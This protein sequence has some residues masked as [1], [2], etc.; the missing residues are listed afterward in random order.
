[1]IS[2]LLFAS[3]YM[4]RS[5]SHKNS[6]CKQQLSDAL[7][8]IAMLDQTVMSLQQANQDLIE[9]HIQKD[10]VIAERDQTVTTLLTKQKLDEQTIAALE[11]KNHQNNQLIDKLNNIVSEQL[12]RLE[13]NK[14]ELFD[15]KMLRY[16]WMQL[17]K[18]IYGRRS[19]KRYITAPPRRSC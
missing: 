17:R 4:K 11:D 9:G 18:M 6:N 12:L 13:K 15:C 3:A 16:Q 10:R 14:S 7:Q 5:S 2:L 1:M 8:M 19:E